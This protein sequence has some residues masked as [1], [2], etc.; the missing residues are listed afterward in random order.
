MPK[1]IESYICSKYKEQS[2]CEDGLFIGDN[3][4]AIIDGVTSKGTLK[5]NGSSSG[6]YAMNVIIN[7]LKNDI[8]TQSPLVFFSEINEK[9]KNSMKLHPKCD[10]KEKPRASVIAYIIDKQEIWSYGDCK[11]IVGEKYYSHEKIIDR[12]LANKRAEIIKQYLINS[13]SISKLQHKDLGREAIMDELKNQFKYENV[14][15]IVDGY[16]YGYPVLNGNII[17]EDMIS[18]H[19]VNKGD[20]VVLASDGYPILKNTLKESE[21]KLAHI[22]DEDPLCYKEY[23]STKGINEGNISFDDRTYIRFEV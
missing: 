2:L 8:S 22:I 13:N 19:F 9:L 1:I 6:Q 16:D 3:I 7:V 20:M 23:K 11:C 14:H 12:I 17:C 10:N 18:V 21:I 15:C 4:I 5:W